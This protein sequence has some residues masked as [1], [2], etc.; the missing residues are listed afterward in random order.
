MNNPGQNSTIDQTVTD[1]PDLLNKCQLYHENYGSDHRA[2]YSEWNLQAQSRPSAKARKSYERAEWVRIGEE[3]AR[4][5]S[6]WRD[7]KPGQHSTMYHP[8]CCH[9]FFDLYHG[10]HIRLII[11]AIVDK[12]EKKMECL[13]NIDSLAW[14]WACFISKCRVFERNFSTVRGIKWERIKCS[15]A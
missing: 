4:Q 3:V 15:V 8:G 6:P 14:W 13:N 1:R 12:I 5:M 11:L 7:I 2:T 10:N 9:W